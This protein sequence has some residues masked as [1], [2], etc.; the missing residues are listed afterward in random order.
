MVTLRWV[1]PLIATGTRSELAHCRGNRLLRNG[2][3]GMYGIVPLSCPGPAAVALGPGVPA[4]R[5]G[6]YG[7]RGVVLK[8]LNSVPLVRVH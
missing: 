5:I 1:A 7:K 3:Y 6:N 8:E 2:Q 4:A